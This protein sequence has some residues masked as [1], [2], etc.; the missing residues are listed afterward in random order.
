MQCTTHFWGH[1]TKCL[2]PKTLHNLE[3]PKPGFQL[4]RRLVCTKTKFPTL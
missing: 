4:G 2:P 1:L 3:S